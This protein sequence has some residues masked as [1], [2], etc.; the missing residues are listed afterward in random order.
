M[1]HSIKILLPVLLVLG[2]AACQ[3]TEKM[4][5]Y[6]YDLDYFAEKG[7]SVVELKGADGQARVL[8]VPA[9]QGRVMTST[10]GGREGAS[11]GWINYKAIDEG[12]VNPQFNPFGGEE[13]FW[14]G[15][16]G[17]PFSWYFKPGEEQVYANWK[18]PAII[19]SEPFDIESVSESGAVFTK[20]C[21]LKNA[22]G[23]T[24]KIGIR[25]TVRLLDPAA[26][27]QLLGVSLPEGIRSVAYGTENTLRNLGESAWTKETGMPSVWLLGMYPPTPSTVV[28]IPYD[29][30]H[31]G[32]IVNDEYFGKVPA[33]R[34]TVRD[35][36]I[37][38]KIDGKYRA[39]IGLP[40]GSAKDLCGS[41]DPKAGVL[42]ILKYTVP[43]GEQDYVN[44]QWGPQ[45][46][47]FNGD[48]INS[49]NDGP[50]ETGVVMGPFYEI[51][52]SS[53]GAALAPGQALTHTQYTLHLEGSPEQLAPIVRTLF[54]ADLETIAKAF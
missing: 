52:T 19:D 25:R 39:K 32:R 34:L 40:S 41:Y 54:G 38:F 9:Y 43:E 21:I 36:M 13:R 2:G 53:P 4:G 26:Q 10:A 47:P 42:N 51:E 14:I 30:E 27:E 3:K 24:F 49:Y 37:Y 6:A 20:D 31:T 8:V 50:T 46:N 15:P 35:G 1:R 5:T 45:E 7:I 12:M 29:K 33:D 48:V 28:F 23:H 17:G 18:V 11:F 44:G 22:S 16:E